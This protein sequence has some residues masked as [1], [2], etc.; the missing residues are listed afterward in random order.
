MENKENEFANNENMQSQ[1]VTPQIPEI[2]SI[3]PIP[4]IGQ[5]TTQSSKGFDESNLDY[6]KKQEEFANK[7]LG[8]T[9]PNNQVN[10]NSQGTNQQNPYSANAAQPIGESTNYQQIPNSGNS[11]NYLRQVNVPNSGGILALGILS[12]V[13]LCCCAGFISPVLSIIALAL[14]PKAKRIY[15]A[16]PQLYKTS[17]LNNLNAGKITAIIGLALATIFII[18]LI[19]STATGSINMNEVNEAINEAWNETGY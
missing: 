17:S 10:S 15:S 13:S 8:F 16:N 14:I 3:P 4:D 2:N 18:Y 6:A 5:N 9:K 19:V 11:N 7:N 1:Q 12:I